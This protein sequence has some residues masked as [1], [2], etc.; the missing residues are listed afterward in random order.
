MQEALRETTKARPTNSRPGFFILIVRETRNGRAPQIRAPEGVPERPLARAR[1][2]STPES[3]P[4]AGPRRSMRGVCFHLP[5]VSRSEDT[6]ASLART[7]A[8]RARA[9]SRFET[10]MTMSPHHGARC[11]PPEIFEEPCGAR[12]KTCS[13]SRRRSRDA[14]VLRVSCGPTHEATAAVKRA[15]ARSAPTEAG[16]R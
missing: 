12:A 6:V 15:A 13:D 1:R 4:E 7:R 2:Q 3:T 8:L 9:I 11:V 10:P 14:R 5:S 16:G